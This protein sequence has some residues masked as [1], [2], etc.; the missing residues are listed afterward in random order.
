MPTFTT[1]GTRDFVSYITGPSHVRLGLRLVRR[2]CGAPSIV[3][4]PPVGTIPF[5]ELDE[6]AIVAAV[7]RGV[8]AVDPTLRAAEIVYVADDSRDYALYA[9]CAMSLAQRFVPSQSPSE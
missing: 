7:E 5:A 4:Q 1:D 2:E 3:R 6:A 9:R 8:A